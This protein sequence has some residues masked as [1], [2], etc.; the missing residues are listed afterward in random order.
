MRHLDISSLLLLFPAVSFSVFLLAM[1]IIHHQQQ[2]HYSTFSQYNLLKKDQMC[3]YI[4]QRL[5][6]VQHM[7]YHMMGRS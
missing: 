1:F 2:W 4:H 6:L 3:E 5:A 7:T